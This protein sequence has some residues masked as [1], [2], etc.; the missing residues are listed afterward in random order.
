LKEVETIKKLIS[1]TIKEKNLYECL[2]LNTFALIS[3]DNG[4]HIMDVMS[5][6]TDN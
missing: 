6:V 2:I 5:N 1:I 4:N 3:S